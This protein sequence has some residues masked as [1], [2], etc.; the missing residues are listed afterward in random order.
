LGVIAIDACAALAACRYDNNIASNSS[1]SIS[2]ADCSVIE[3]FAGYFI[4]VEVLE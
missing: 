4:T 3:I 1:K 2:V